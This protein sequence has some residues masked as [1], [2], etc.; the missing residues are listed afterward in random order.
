MSAEWKRLSQD[1]KLKLSGNEIRVPC[2]NNRSHKVY[3][4]DSRDEAIRLWAVVV[5]RG[6]APDNAALESWKINRYRELIGFRLAEYGRVIGEAW[7]PLTG[8]SLDEWKTYVF[9][10]ARACD[11][12]EYLW[13]GKDV[14]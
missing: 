11:R 6:D 12:L 8:L 3:V 4:D 5:T 2:G 14:E 10:L 7:V 13:T 1:A 9:T